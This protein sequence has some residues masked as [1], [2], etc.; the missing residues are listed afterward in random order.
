MDLTIYQGC[1]EA[2]NLC[3]MKVKHGVDECGIEWQDGKPVTM[4]SAEQALH[5][6]PASWGDAYVKTWCCYDWRSVACTIGRCKQDWFDT[7]DSACVSDMFTG[8]VYC[9]RYTF[10]HAFD[11]N[12]ESG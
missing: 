3:T 5:S 2:N 7:P 10:K 11:A 6:N 1:N 4:F 9:G 8:D 12:R